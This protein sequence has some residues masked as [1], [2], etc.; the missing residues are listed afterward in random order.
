MSGKRTAVVALR[1]KISAR[2]AMLRSQPHHG[3]GSASSTGR[4]PGGE[5]P[6]K[7]DFCVGQQW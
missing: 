2:L 3:G 1:K 6:M 4:G 7:K 5:W